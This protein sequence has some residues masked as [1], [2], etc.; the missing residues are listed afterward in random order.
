MTSGTV[1]GGSSAGDT[2]AG[3]DTLGLISM[4]AGRVD[5]W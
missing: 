1:Y 4:A 3:N 5:R 2:A